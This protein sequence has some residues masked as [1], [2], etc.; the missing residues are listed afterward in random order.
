[1]YNSFRN[2]PERIAVN[3]VI[4]G[5]AA[6]LI[7]Q[8]M[9][10]IYQCMAEEKLQSRMLLQIHDELVFEVPEEERRQMIALVEEQMIAAG[11]NLDVPLVVDIKTGNDWGSCMPVV[12]E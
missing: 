6:D 1:M 3:T 7:K 2:L 8:A 12:K 11:D 4:Q 9:I 10:R 5:S